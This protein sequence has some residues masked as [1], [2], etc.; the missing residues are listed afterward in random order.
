MNDQAIIALARFPRAGEVKSRLTRLISPQEA[1]DLY[2]GFLVD[3]LEQYASLGLS[4]RLYMAGGHTPDFPVYN[5]TIRTQCGDGFGQRMQHAFEETAQAGYKKIVI[6]GTD[7]PTLPLTYIRR[8]FDAL[9]EA[10]AIAIGPVLDGGY[11]LLG[12]N[13]PIYDLFD[14]IEY[15]RPDV[16]ELTLA[17]AYQSGANVTQLPKWYDIDTPEDLRRLAREEASVPIHTMK[18]LKQ[19]KVKYPL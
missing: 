8:A 9:S 18:I 17:K 4:V 19:L 14:G 1:A 2:R 5:A 16:Y 10:P 3:S 12:M 11:Y 15:S 13:P 6:I 7:H